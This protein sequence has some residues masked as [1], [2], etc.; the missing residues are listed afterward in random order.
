MLSF[1]R[2]GGRPDR[3]TIPEAVKRVADGSLTLVDVRDISELKAGGKAKG[4][5]HV[6]LMLLAARADPRHP[7]HLSA[8]SPAGAVA[9]YCASGARSGM[10]V[11]LLEKLGYAEVHNL[12]G[13]ADWRNGG[14]AVVKA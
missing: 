7:E 9:V 6:P 3:L 8:L 12:G 13:L 10:A 1:L 11:R 4:A 14:G 2:P 5:L